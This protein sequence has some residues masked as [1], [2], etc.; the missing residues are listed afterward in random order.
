VP[1][2][3][4][5]AAPAAD[6]TDA[7]PFEDALARLEAIVD[8]LEGGELPLEQTLARFEEGVRLV[9]TCQ[10]R[11]EDAE[12]RLKKLEQVA[13]GGFIL[14]PVAEVAEE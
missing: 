7:L 11:L 13:G 10:V 8:A 1:S 6:G 14:K 9:R 5:N 2:S 3:T 4:K 12:V